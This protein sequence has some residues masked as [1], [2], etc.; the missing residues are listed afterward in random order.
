[1]FDGALPAARDRPRT[2]YAGWSA[3]GSRARVAGWWPSRLVRARPRRVHRATS[4]ARLIRRTAS[5]F[6]GIP[7]IGWHPGRSTG[8]DLRGSAEVARH[9]PWRML[10][11]P[12]PEGAGQRTA[13]LVAL[14][15]GLPGLPP[16]RHMTWRLARLCPAFASAVNR[17]GDRIRPDEGRPRRHAEGL[18]RLHPCKHP[19]E[20]PHHRT[21]GVGI[22]GRGRR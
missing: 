18:R 19:G 9:G 14:Q 22:N 21:A 16:F 2:G 7:P 13:C 1:M 8:A 4:P 10:A 11:G 5:S 15:L 12:V 6:A 3:P 17:F 20:R